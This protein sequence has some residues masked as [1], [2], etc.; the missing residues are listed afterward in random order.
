MFLQSMGDLTLGSGGTPFSYGYLTDHVIGE[1][2]PGGCS[3][4]AAGTQGGGRLSS[5]QHMAGRDELL[6]EPCQSAYKAG[7]VS[8]LDLSIV[9]V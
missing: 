9:L 4:V 7:P 5:P 8:I 3:G 1:R 2:I 6:G